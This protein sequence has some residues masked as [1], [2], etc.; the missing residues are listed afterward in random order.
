MSR[1]R[2]R[3]PSIKLKDLLHKLAKL[4]LQCRLAVAERTIKNLNS[5]ATALEMEKM[6]LQAV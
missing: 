5:K 4:K 2:A 1:T 6:K 3:H